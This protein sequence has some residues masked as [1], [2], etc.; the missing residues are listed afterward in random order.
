MF[1]N[2][3]IAGAGAMAL[4]VGIGLAGM[5][6]GAAMN[7]EENAGFAAKGE[8]S[9]ARDGL[10]RQE[11]M[12]EHVDFSSGAVQCEIRTMEENGALVLENTVYSLE[13]VS[14]IYRL[15]VA[16]VGGRNRSSIQQGGYFSTDEHGQTDIGKMMLADPGAI[17]EVFLSIEAEGQTISCQKTV[18]V[19]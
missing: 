14:G 16:S 17:Y 18:G 6:T 10:G 5:A 11:V 15:K 9:A 12:E 8:E 19:S 13:P 3:G 1:D 2:K 4:L 7:G